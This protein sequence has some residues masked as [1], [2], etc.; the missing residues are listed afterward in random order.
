MSSFV[1]QRANHKPEKETLFTPPPTGSEHKKR[2]R[3]PLYAAL[4]DFL[5][6]G[7]RLLKKGVAKL[8][9]LLS[10]SWWINPIISS[11]GALLP[12]QSWWL[13]EKTHSYTWARSI[14]LSSIGMV[15]FVA[16]LVGYN[17]NPALMGS[18]GILPAN[19]YFNPIKNREPDKWNGFTSMPSIFWFLD[20]TDRNMNLINLSGLGLSTLV[21][22]GH[23]NSIT[24]GVLWL[25]YHTVVT[26]AGGTRFYGY[27]WESQILETGFLGIF[28]ASPWTLFGSSSRLPSVASIWAFRWL[29]FRITL[30]A[31]LIKL[32]GARCWQERTALWYHFETQPVPNPMSPVFHFLPKWMLSNAV[33]LDFTV[34]LYLSWLV[35]LPGFGYLRYLRLAGGIL[36]IGFMLN[37]AISGN[38][39]FL[40]WLT[41]IPPIAC[42]DDAFFESI[43]GTSGTDN[44][45]KTENNVFYYLEMATR[46]VMDFSLCYLVLTASFPVIA[47]LLQLGGRS[48][49]MNTSYGPW[50][51]L[52]TYGAFGSV[53]ERRFEPIVSAS[54]DGETWHEFHFKAKP[55]RLDKRPVSIQPYHYRLD[56]NIWFIGFPPHTSYL[57][58]R[59]YWMWPFLAKLLE[60]DTLTLG[61]LDQ[62][63][64]KSPIYYPDGPFGERKLPKWIKVDMWRYEMISPW[65]TDTK[66]WWKRTYK[67]SLI[68]PQTRKSW[69]LNNELEK[70][71]L[72][73][74]VQR[75]PRPN[76]SRKSDKERFARNLMRGSK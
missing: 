43:F 22:L 1:R 53:G 56:W 25:L 4:R 69:K 33:H 42:L 74:R 67:Q 76:S 60:G 51:I 19:L 70:L 26:T 38:L 16:F 72:H 24:L 31:G 58:R 23:H 13:S 57:R 6:I 45:E 40:N 41:I 7:Y 75:E 59:E 73:D 34:Q 64:L 52:N 2:R 61:L 63:N 9:K 28:L 3:P 17:Q 12:R 65:R 37:I 44:T 10:P 14:I 21:T 49:V 71:R 30:G 48:Q 11:A 54:H 68:E 66:D 55:G 47:N 62:C 50:K 15:Y 46:L 18:N 5:A 27:G 29:I 35:L 8:R 32:R 36:Q 39:A 20:L